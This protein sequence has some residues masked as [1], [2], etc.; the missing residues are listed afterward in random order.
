MDIWEITAR[1]K[2]DGMMRFISH[3]DFVR[4]IYRALRRA[5]IPFVMTEGFSPHPKVKFGQA[6]KLGANGEMA[7]IFFL[8]IKMDLL[9]FKD[10]MN[11]QLNQDLRIIEINYA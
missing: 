3:L 11:R 9:E 10:K 1:F 7:V 4:L 2:K 6:L 8:R 5:Q